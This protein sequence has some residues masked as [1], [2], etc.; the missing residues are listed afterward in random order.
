MVK[1]LI[2]LLEAPILIVPLVNDIHFCD[3]F[4]EALI[5]DFKALFQ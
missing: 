4:I 3:Q 1:A 5:L 2:L